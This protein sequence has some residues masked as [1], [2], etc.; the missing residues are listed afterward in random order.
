[1]TRRGYNRISPAALRHTLETVAADAFGVPGKNVEADLRDDGGT[2]GAAISVMLPLPPLLQPSPGTGTPPA[3]G[4]LFEQTRAARDTIL[5]RGADLS[6]L[7]MGTV[8]ITLTGARQPHRTSR[9]DGGPHQG[10]RRGGPQRE[11]HRTGPQQEHHEE[12]RPA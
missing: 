2:L 9:V 7:L 4:T 3:A 1:M 8:D 12:R 10:G 6:G 5:R 11:P